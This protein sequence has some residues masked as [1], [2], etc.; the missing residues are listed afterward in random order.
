MSGVLPPARFPPPLS[1]G[2]WRERTYRLLKQGPTQRL[3]F[4]HR[5]LND[6]SVACSHVLSHLQL[7]ISNYF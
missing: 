6:L 5:F 3:G 2:L 4:Y 1:Q 7:H